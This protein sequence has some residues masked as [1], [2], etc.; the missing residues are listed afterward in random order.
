MPYTVI[1]KDTVCG[2]TK[3]ILQEVMEEYGEEP[4]W[5]GVKADSDARTV[6]FVDR[7][8]GSWSVVMLLKEVA[9]LIDSGEES[10]NIEKGKKI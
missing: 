7:E 6:L 4:V 8:T 1:P 10:S 3:D 5:Y 9:C 2:P